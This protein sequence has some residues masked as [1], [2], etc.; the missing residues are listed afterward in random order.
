M[1]IFLPTVEGVDKECGLVMYHE[2]GENKFAKHSARLRPRKSVGAR[3]DHSVS[4]YLLLVTVSA[5][6]QRWEIGDEVKLTVY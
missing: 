4:E 5:L 1:H 3:L 6:G 2:R